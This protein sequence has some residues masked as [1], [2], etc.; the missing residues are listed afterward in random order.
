MAEKIRRIVPNINTNRME[1]SVKFYTA[2]LGLQIAMDMGWIVTLISPNNPSAQ[3][4]I[5][6]EQAPPD[7]SRSHFSL[8]IEVGDVDAV[9][10]R[11]VTQGIEIIYPLTNEPWDVKR[12]HV[13]DP[14]G[15]T[16]NVMSHNT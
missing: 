1:E 5:V 10:S 12:F 7:V 13:V 14:N 9:H 11:A 15:V 2:F 16:I 3:I 6:R 8:T 4:S